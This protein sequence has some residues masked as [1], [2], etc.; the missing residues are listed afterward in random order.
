MTEEQ[1]KEE[2]SNNYIG[3]IASRG[4]F[5]LIK[6]PD[7]G[8]VD[9]S[10]KYDSTYTLP[11]GKTRF[12]QSQDSIDIQLKST[13]E[14]GSLI[15]QF[16]DHIKYDL[17]VKTYNDLIERNKIGTYVPL[18]LILFILPAE[19]DKWVTVNEDCLQLSKSAFWFKPRPDETLTS[20]QD[21][22]R[23]KIPLANK[24]ALNTFKELFE[25]FH[26][27]E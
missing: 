19:E 12:L 10:V 4:G 5:K 7:T 3:T 14:G 25:E 26:P 8:G 22:K 17:E 15:K 16:D 9:F 18:I 6:P 2:L 1:I 13:T 20:N 24:L 11:S 23:I 21:R 27:N